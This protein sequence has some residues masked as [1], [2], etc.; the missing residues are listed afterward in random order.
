MLALAIGGAA[1]VIVD[2]MD[3]DDLAVGRIVDLLDGRGDVHRSG[4]TLLFHVRERKLPENQEAA[5]FRA[6]LEFF[7]F[8]PRRDETDQIVIMRFD[9]MLT[10]AN[11]LAE[12]AISFPFRSWMLLS[13]MRLPAKKWSE[14]LKEMS[15]RFPRDA[16][17]YRLMQDSIVRE[18]MLEAQVGMMHLDRSSHTTSPSA[19][20]YM[21]DAV[22]EPV[23][24]YLCLGSPCGNSEIVDQFLGRGGSPGRVEESSE[25][26]YYDDSADDNLIT[27][28]D[29]H[30]LGDPGTPRSDV[31]DE[32][33][34]DEEFE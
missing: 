27:V 19:G 13:L 7:A 22:P 34:W 5:M 31:T 18:K 11:D 29:V 10:K 4:P 15:H 33:Q 21:I 1:R 16:D 26:A 32:E 30:E 12:L 25:R 3:D 28:Y 2:E 9:S 8:T 20:I 24:L 17:E 6:G 14:Y 23:P